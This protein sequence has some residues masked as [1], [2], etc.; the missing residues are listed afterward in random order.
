MD[1]IVQAVDMGRE[2]VDRVTHLVAR[3]LASPL[4]GVP[5]PEQGVDAVR[6]TLA[7]YCV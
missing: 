3:L 6:D 4:E 1:G 7:V 5:G 2:V